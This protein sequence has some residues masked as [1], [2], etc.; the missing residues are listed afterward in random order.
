MDRTVQNNLMLKEWAFSVQIWEPLTRF[1]QGSQ[2][3]TFDQAS[4]EDLSV[5]MQ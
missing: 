1:S 4:L 3:M 2:N 5:K